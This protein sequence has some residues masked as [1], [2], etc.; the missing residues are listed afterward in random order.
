MQIVNGVNSM[1]FLT[2]DNMYNRA[3]TKVFDLCLLSILTAICCIPIVTIG[4]AVSAMYA[5]MM[6]MSKNIEGPIIASYFKE[7][8]QNL[9]GSIPGSVIFMAGVALL[10]FDLTAWTQNEIGGRSLYY[11]YTIIVFLFFVSVSD[12]YFVVRAR[13][14]ETTVQA[15]GNAFRFAMAFLPITVVCGAYTI[16]IIWVITRYAILIMFFPLAGFALLC[17]PKALLMG[18]KIDYYIEDKGL[19]PESETDDDDWE[20]PEPD[21]VEIKQSENKL[22]NNS[23]NG[24]EED[25]NWQKLP[26]KDKLSYILYNH[27]AGVLFGLLAVCLIIGLGYHFIFNGNDCCF[28]LAVVN[29]YAKESDGKLSENLD[30]MFELDGNRKYAY[31]DTEYQISYETD[32]VNIENIAAD[33]SFYDKFFLNIRTGQID[34]AI[35]PKSFFDYCNSLGNIF[36]DVGYVLSD[37]QEDSFSNRFVV[38]KTEDG[39]HKNG[40]EVGKCNYLKETGITFI[41]VNRDDEYIL[42]FPINGSHIDKC[43]DFVDHIGIN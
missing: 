43:R 15:Y 21:D 27:T 22:G 23:E 38:G 36:Y 35:I 26:F 41:D 39:D 9:K 12:W 24:L 32:G 18:K 13:F 6:K 19:V 7:L 17:Y 4:A 20:F 29:S 42:V 28:N 8:K 3:M 31:V 14:E 16:L 37:E 1:G 25:D 34:A 10:S 11:G 30:N 33:N 2:G 40:I 5:V